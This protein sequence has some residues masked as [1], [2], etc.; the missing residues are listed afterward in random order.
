MT[1]WGF[2]KEGRGSE[3][4]RKELRGELGCQPECC[5]A[6]Q[7]GRTPLHVVAAAVHMTQRDDNA[8]AVVEQL[9]AAG[10][11]TE[12][13]D[14]VRVGGGCGMRIGQGRGVEWQHAAFR[15][16]LFSLRYR[17]AFAP[18]Q[19]LTVPFRV[20]LIWCVLHVIIHALRTCSHGF[21]L[22]KASVVAYK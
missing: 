6:P 11:D 18:D 21:V 16:M 1:L 10:A 4:G 8:V 7:D 20:D 22:W 19:R 12:A 5:R 14:E 15:V 2:G 17:A 3:R 9:L 13:E